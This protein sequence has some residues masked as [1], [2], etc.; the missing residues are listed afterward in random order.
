MEFRQFFGSVKILSLLVEYVAS[1]RNDKKRM[2]MK[3]HK[4]GLVLDLRKG[5][6]VFLASLTI[7]FMAYVFACQITQRNSE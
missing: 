5:V 7:H 4:K 3:I 1:V 6:N 2:A